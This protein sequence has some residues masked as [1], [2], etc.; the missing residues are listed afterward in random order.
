MPILM[1]PMKPATTSNYLWGRSLSRPPRIRSWDRWIALGAGIVMGLTPAPVEWFPL[2]WIAIAPLWVILHRRIDPD[3]STPALRQAAGLGFLWGL[4]YHGLAL[5]WIT[6]VHPMDWMGVPWLASITIALV[7]WVFI[8]CWGAGISTLWAIA[9]AWVYRRLQPSPWLGILW[10]TALWCAIEWLWSRGALYWSA[11]AYSQSPHNLLALHLG[12]IAGPWT[13][14]AA[15]VAV[16]GLLAQAWLTRSWRPAARTYGGGAIALLLAVHLLGGWLYGQP[17]HDDPAERLTVGIIQGNIPN[18]I[19]LFDEGWRKAI[20]GYTTGYITL[21]N[22]GVDVVLTPETALPTVWTGTLH[23]RTSMY[24]AI[25]EQQTPIW[26]GAFGG[27]GQD[28]ANSLFTVL[29][30][31]SIYSEY[32]KARLV[33]LGEYIP[34]ERWLG[35]LI[36]RLSPLDARLIPGDLNPIFDTPFGR[37]IVGICYES[38][39]PQHFQQQ[40]A[41]GGTLLL[42]ASN[43][44]HYAESMPAQHHAQDVMRAIE[45]D[46]WAVRATNTGYSGIVDPHGRT[47]WMSGINTYELYRHQVYRRQTQTLYVRWGNWLT[48]VLWLGAIAAS[49]I[50]YWRSRST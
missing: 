19:K 4:G 8:A 22:Q 27:S 38:A 5:S 12:Q 31:G 7:C 25:R 35:G 16:N 36:S 23:T 43:N 30:D 32:R 20:E 17:L 50:Q 10:G 29:G 6:G 44:A 15:L 9:M 46:R 21:S 28:L 11:I 40:T 13:V 24:Q 47:L 41:R 14:T 3:A 26:L 45:S 39:F 33:P 37:M 34:F 2:G 42:T 49:G 18:T 1:E 48:P